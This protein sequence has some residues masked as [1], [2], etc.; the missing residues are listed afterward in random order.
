[1]ETK[2][3]VH[4]FNSSRGLR[5]YVPALVI[6]RSAGLYLIPRGFGN[7]KRFQ[8]LFRAAWQRIPFSYRRLMVK[9]WRCGEDPDS[10]LPWS[11]NIQLLDDWIHAVGWTARRKDGVVWL[12]QQRGS[13]YTIISTGGHRLFFHAPSMDAMPDNIVQDIV[14]HELAHVCQA[15]EGDDRVRE[16]ES[17]VLDLGELDANDMI[18]AWGFDADSVDVW[19]DERRTAAASLAIVP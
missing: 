14:A 16:E 19:E 9:H 5:K 10:G 15:A 18:D 3:D 2:L 17:G 12:M 1:M 8:K 7:D 4:T 13:E 6:Q 11:P